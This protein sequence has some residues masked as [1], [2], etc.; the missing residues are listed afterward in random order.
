MSDSI[1]MTFKAFQATGYDSHVAQEDANK[2]AAYSNAESMSWDGAIRVYLDGSVI[3]CKL[4]DDT[5]FFDDYKERFTGTFEEME[6]ALYEF[7]VSEVLDMD[8]PIYD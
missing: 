1:E 8:A 7:S 6:R 2:S 4:D 5:Y 3:L